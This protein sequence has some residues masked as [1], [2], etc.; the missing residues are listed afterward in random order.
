MVVRLVFHILT[1][2][3]DGSFLI[4]CVQIYSMLQ[5]RIFSGILLNVCVKEIIFLGWPD[6]VWLKGLFKFHHVLNVAASDY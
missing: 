1:V 2:N 4:I 3:H 5:S 6:P